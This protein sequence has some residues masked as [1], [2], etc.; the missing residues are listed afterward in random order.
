VVKKKEYQIEFCSYQWKRGIQGIQESEESEESKYHMDIM[1]MCC[2]WTY[3][4][5]E[6]KLMNPD[7]T[8]EVI[9]EKI[10]QRYRNRLT[11]YIVSY[12]Q[13]MHPILFELSKNIYDG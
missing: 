5:I 12:Q 3:L 2:S 9:E 13:I 8:V 4:M 10:R 11:R 1:G 6:L 7:M